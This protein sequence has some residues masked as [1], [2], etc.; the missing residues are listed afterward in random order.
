MFCRP[1]VS[2]LLNCII[3][4]IQLTKGPRWAALLYIMWC[5]H[6]ETLYQFCYSCRTFSHFN[7]LTNKCT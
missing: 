6:L 1:I 7:T 4:T 2:C 5:C 3:E